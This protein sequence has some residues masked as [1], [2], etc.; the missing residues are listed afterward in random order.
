MASDGV[1]DHCVELRK[2]VGFLGEGLKGG[3]G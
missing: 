1:T 2:C 3:W